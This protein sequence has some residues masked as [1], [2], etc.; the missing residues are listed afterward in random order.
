MTDSDVMAAI[1]RE[2]F[3]LRADVGAVGP[4]DAIYVR[5]RGNNNASLEG[6]SR[7]P[8]DFSWFGAADDILAR[9]SGLPDG[10]GPEVVRSEFHMGV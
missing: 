2:V 1:R 6:S 5:D 7:A 8:E 4:K 10:A 3:R 9:L